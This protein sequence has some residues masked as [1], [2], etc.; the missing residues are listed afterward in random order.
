MGSLPVCMALACLVAVAA[1]PASAAAD[2]VSGTQTTLTC[3]DG[4]SVAVSLDQTALANLVT[5]V[6]ALNATGTDNCAVAT[7]PSGATA[8]WTVYDYN[9]S[10]REIAPRHS[11]NSMPATTTGTT[12]SFVF[13]DNVYT[14]LL[15]TTDSSLTGDLSTTTLNDTISLSGPASGF[16]TQD[17]GGDCASNTPA[18]VR[19]Y[20]TSPSASG[21]SGGS[22]PAG[23]Y[24]K[25]W[26][27]NPESLQLLTGDQGPEMISASMSDPGMWS[28]WNGQSGA[29][30]A[31][32]EAFTE[33]VQNVQS[34]GLS[35]G[36]DC[37]FETGVTTT[38]NTGDTEE[39]SSD[40]TES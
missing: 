29:N 35:F 6:N 13:K 12:T 24:T 11:P 18:A 22:P 27:S 1:W 28:D 14:A 2:V 10:G 8:D 36:G 23:F 31:V 4:H 3:S 21:S 25:F 40:F 38:S 33:A 16:M 15:T 32:T 5:E 9:P 34:V 26:W 39:L 19:F 37:F 30:P 7:D 20:F 17:D